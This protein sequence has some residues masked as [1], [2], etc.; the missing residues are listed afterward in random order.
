MTATSALL[1]RDPDPKDKAA[2]RALWAGYLAF[3]EVDVPEAVTAR[4][5]ARLFD[6]DTP[7]FGRFAE[8]DGMIVGFSISTLHP[9]T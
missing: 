2:W 5:W 3:Y 6:R 4:T 9:S 7:M 8:R 1:I